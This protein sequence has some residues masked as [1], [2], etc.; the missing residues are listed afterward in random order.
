MRG[1]FSTL[2]ISGLLAAGPAKHGTGRPAMR[3]RMY[4]IACLAIGLVSLSGCESSDSENA[5]ITVGLINAPATLAVNQ[6]VNLT[7]SVNDSSNAGV[8]WSCSP[9]GACGSFNPTHTGD[10]GVTVFT[11]PSSPGTITVTATSTA[12]KSV[13]ASATISVVA[14]DSNA[15]LNGSYVFL[16]QGIDTNGAYFA[17]GTI[18]ADGQGNITGGE[19]DYAG[20]D[21]AAGPDGVTGSYSIGPDGRGSITLNVSNPNL[22]NNGVETFS[23]ALTS[24]RHALIIQFDGTATSS[25]TLDFQTAGSTD[26]GAVSGVYAFAASGF[27]ITK[28]APLAY[29]GITGLNAAAGAVAG[30]KVYA[31]DGGS[32]AE[33]DLA[34]TMTAPDSFGRGTIAYSIGLNL[35]YYVVRGEV[36]RFIEPD[37]TV[38]ASAGTAYAQGSLGT[39]SGFSN[40]SLKGSYA[41][42]ESGSSTVGSLGLAGQFTADGNGSFTTAVV[43]TNNAGTVSGGSIAGQN[44]YSIAANGTGNLS[45]PG[46]SGTTQDAASLLLFVTDPAINLLDPN[47]SSGGGGALIVDIDAGAVAAGLIVPQS[48]GD[49]RGDYAVNLEVFTSA[50]QIDLVGQSVADAAANLTGTVDINDTGTTTS[51]ASLSGASTADAANP[52]RWTGTLTAGS[53]TFKIVYYQVSSAVLFVLDVNTTDVGNGFLEAVAPGS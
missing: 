50:S 43:D 42:Y 29:G 5:N 14:V 24:S 7:A 32:Y 2:L 34:G 35:V 41:F 1:Y 46:T 6:S 13:S 16:V 8:D 18:L 25:G 53:N 11:A 48:A 15:T 37:E 20:A 36:L 22:P 10:N 21:S 19:Q 12:N 31:N 44:V 52:G 30:G 28:D 45:L 49:F 38:T 47:S 23:I 17:A 39:S 27:N 9:S 3:P 33:Y 4:L 40:A 26:A 51:G